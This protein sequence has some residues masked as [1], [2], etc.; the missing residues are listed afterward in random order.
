MRVTVT[1]LC[2]EQ[3]KEETV[4]LFLTPKS[5]ILDRSASFRS[6]AGSR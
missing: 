4:A 3:S 5:E 6:S 2:K 1:R